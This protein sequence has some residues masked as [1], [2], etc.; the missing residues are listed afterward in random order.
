MSPIESVVERLNQATA[1]D[2]AMAVLKR[3]WIHLSGSERMMIIPAGRSLAGKHK[4]SRL[5]HKRECD[6][7]CP[8]RQSR[9]EP[10]H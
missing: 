4:A 9:R 8:Q 7:E 6:R 5:C 3:L 1:P 2:T 10:C